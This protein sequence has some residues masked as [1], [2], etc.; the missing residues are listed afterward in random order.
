MASTPE[1]TTPLGYYVTGADGKQVRVHRTWSDEQ[2]TDMLKRA[3]AIV[4]ECDPP[5]D[6]R[7][8]TFGAAVNLTGQFIEP[9]AKVQVPQLVPDLR[10]N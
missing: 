8:A 3:L 7:L 9:A 6:L 4:L 10:R 2:V 1:T 5:D